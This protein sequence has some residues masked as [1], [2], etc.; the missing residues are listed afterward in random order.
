MSNMCK[1]CILCKQT[2]N[3]PRDKLL[4]VLHLFHVQTED[5]MLAIQTRD[6]EI[7]FLKKQIILMNNIPNNIP[8][9]MTKDIKNN[10]IFIN[11]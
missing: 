3:A 2:Q 1:E 5:A 4:D 10:N 7:E 8:N 11:K 9:I 6:K